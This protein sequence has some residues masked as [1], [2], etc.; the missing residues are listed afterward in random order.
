MKDTTPLNYVE[1]AICTECPYPPVVERL[2]GEDGFKGAR[3]LHMSLGISNEIGEIY[4]AAD[5]CDKAHSSTG[6]LIEAASLLIREEIGD[7]CWYTAGACDVMGIKFIHI[8]K[9]EPFD[10]ESLAD[11]DVVFKQLAIGAGMIAEQVKKHVFYG[12]QFDHGVIVVGLGEVAHSAMSLALFYDLD[13]NKILVDNIAKLATRFPDK[14]TEA[15]A[16]D[17]DK[18]AEYEAMDSDE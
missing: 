9:A 6:P 11:L 1:R 16:I 14:F 5:A 17:R 7:L 8:M 10:P 18:D 15:D 4:E 3:L 13:F 12:K 2:S